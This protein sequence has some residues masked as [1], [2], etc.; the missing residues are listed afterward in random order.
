MKHHT[1]TATNA[2][3][4]ASIMIFEFLRMSQP[5]S[6]FH[7]SHQIIPNVQIVPQKQPEIKTATVTQFDKVRL[8]L[9]DKGDGMGQM[10]TV[11][12]SCRLASN[13]IS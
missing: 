4:A 1:L 10:G 6:L 7:T 13:V 9:W 11:H 12:A 5:H 3:I 2:T 8:F